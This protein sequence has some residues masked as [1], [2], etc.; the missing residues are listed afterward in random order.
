MVQIH[1]S[2]VA[3]DGMALLLRGPSG[4]GKSDLALRLVDGGARLV[5]DDRVDLAPDGKGG[6][7]ARC[8]QAIA[9]LLEVRGLGVLPVP[10]MDAAP[11]CLI[12]DLGTPD[13]RLPDPA[14]DHIAGVTLPRICLNP[15]HS[16]TP[17]KLRLAVAALA[18][19]WPLVPGEAAWRALS[20]AAA[21]GGRA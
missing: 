12:V 15:F 2:C 8:P 14:F 18:R 19:G 1:A 21:Q 16:S 17:A 9:G 20:G 6:L 5:A 3:I 13:D 11:L 4:A 7:I 10:T